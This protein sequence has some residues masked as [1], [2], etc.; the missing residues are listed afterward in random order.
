MMTTTKYE[1]VKAICARWQRR[2]RQYERRIERVLKDAE[3]YRARNDPW[4][5]ATLEDFALRAE[6]EGEM[7]KNSK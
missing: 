1:S 4:S 6:W 5:A 2:Y 7:E 3:Q